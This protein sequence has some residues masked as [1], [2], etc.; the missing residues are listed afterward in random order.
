MSTRDVYWH[1][2]IALKG[3]GVS[4]RAEFECNVIMPCI[5]SY[6]HVHVHVSQGHSNI[7]LSYSN[8]INRTINRTA[9]NDRDNPKQY[10]R[11]PNENYSIVS[12]D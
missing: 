2:I 11:P 10:D 4:P 5:P 7:T 12:Q 9:Q 8:T 3:K 1:I 6:I